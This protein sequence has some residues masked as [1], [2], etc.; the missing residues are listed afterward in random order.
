[1]HDSIALLVTIWLFALV[2]ALAARAVLSRDLLDRALAIDLLSI[3]GVAV[4]GVI[5][6]QKE[7]PGFLDAA[8]VL[9]LLSYGQTVALA[10]FI[11]ER[12]SRG[13]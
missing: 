12:R 5:A 3:A 9:A 10:H 7:R 8:F 2:A 6:A 13:R 11:L 4:L 1:M